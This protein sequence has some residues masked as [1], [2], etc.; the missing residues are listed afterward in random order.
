MKKPTLR[1][2]AQA[3]P[4]KRA[5]KP[6]VSLRGGV[7]AERYRFWFIWIMVGALF[8]M[9]AA[10]AFTMQVQDPEAM[11][12]EQKAQ[13]LGGL[14]GSETG[15]LGVDSPDQVTVRERTQ[16]YLEIDRRERA[17]RGIIYDRNQVPLAISTP[18]S[19]TIFNPRQYF[20]AKY[21]W[22][23]QYDKKRSA[24]DKDRNLQGISDL[25]EAHERESAKYDLDALAARL[26]IPREKIDKS[27]ERTKR[28]DRSEIDAGFR[29]SSDEPH[30]QV[31]MPISQYAVLKRGMTPKR[32]ADIQQDFKGISTETEFRRY[33]PQPQPNAQLLGFMGR[34]T[35]DGLTDF[36]GVEGIEAAYNTELRGSDGLIRDIW[37]SNGMGIIHSELASP[38]SATQPGAD[39]TLT[40]DSRLQYLLYRELERSGRALSAE[41]ASGIVVDVQT[42]EVLAMSSWPSYNPNDMRTRVGNS[43]KN[44]VVT[45]TFEPGSV[46]KP[47][48]VSAGLESGLY[49]PDSVINIGNGVLKMRGKTFREEHYHG[50]DVSLYDLI[51]KSS[52]LA[53]IKIGL[54][55]PQ[56]G[57]SSMQRNFGLGSR[58]V[59]DMVGEQTGSL[60]DPDVSDQVMRATQTYGYGLSV[61][62][63]QMAQAYSTLA[64]H[65]R[66]MKLTLVKQQ[67]DTGRQIVKPETADAVVDMMRGVVVYGSGKNAAIPGYQ[68]AGKTGTARR[69]QGGSYQQG[70]YRGIFIG[71]APASNPRFVTAIKVEDPKGSRYYGGYVAAPIFARVTKEA[72]RLEGVPPDATYLDSTESPL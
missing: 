36:V 27:F 52:N 25:D 40:I 14:A 58:K 17:V 38:D 72:L 45:D 68:V 55:L 26:K 39:V 1:K 15:G 71:I 62:L 48:T 8:C 34:R 53:S 57:I 69:Y 54:S 51:A 16:R 12:A 28:V 30:M 47:I 4:V 2:K 59:F 10:R 56:D 32:A 49:Q 7:E 23:Y 43:A 29:A 9:L 65:G 18:M 5:K 21:L 60:R 46:V 24:L 66:E 63:A 61:T 50:P 3:K 41:S 19:T 20:I 13:L 11:T 33:Y 64:N 6:S 35:I 42:G 22:E 70:S 67:N 37:A 44:R 31:D